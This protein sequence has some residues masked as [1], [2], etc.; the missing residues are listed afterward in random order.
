VS[1]EAM[2][3]RFTIDVGHD[4]DSGKEVAAVVRNDDT[5]LDLKV[6]DALMELGQL[7][8]ET[9]DHICDVIYSLVDS[10]EETGRA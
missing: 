6:V 3:G 1:L 8:P 2:A 5:W 7:F 10:W 4:A 9:C